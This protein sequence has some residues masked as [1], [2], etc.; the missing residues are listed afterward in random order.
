MYGRRRTG[1]T[2]D[3]IIQPESVLPATGSY[4]FW[5]LASITG[6]EYSMIRVSPKTSRPILFFSPI[7][8][9]PATATT[10]PHRQSSIQLFN[11]CGPK[12]ESASVLSPVT[13]KAI[14]FLNSFRQTLHLRALCQ[15]ISVFVM[16]CE[17]GSFPSSLFSLLTHYCVG[18]PIFRCFCRSCL[19]WRPL[20]HL[21]SNFLT[22]SSFLCRPLPSV[23]SN[24]LSNYG[25][26]TTP[27]TEVCSRCICQTRGYR[28]MM[29]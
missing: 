11:Q 3:I 8:S 26:T 17:Y 6:R 21:S 28:F 16:S 15:F 9:S 24:L 14:W 13:E 25:M 5:P 7:S 4:C 18:T 29:S 20:L 27:T 19:L 12:A 22:G 1:W 2:R 23:V 10:E